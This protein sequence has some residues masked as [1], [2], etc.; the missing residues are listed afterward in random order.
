MLSI[1]HGGSELISEWRFV[2]SFVISHMISHILKLGLGRTKDIKLAGRKVTFSWKHRVSKEDKINLVEDS[3][4]PF[5]AGQLV[6]DALNNQNI[7]LICQ[8]L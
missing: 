8:L 2:L 7:R 5:Y 3:T 1:G 6:V 4:L